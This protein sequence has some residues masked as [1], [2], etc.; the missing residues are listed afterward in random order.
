[1]RKI[2]LT[3]LV[4]LLGGVLLPVA[5]Q[6][7]YPPQLDAALRDLSQRIGVTITVPQLDAWTFEQ[8]RFT[9]TGLGCPEVTGAPAPDGISAYIFD[10]TYQGITYNYRVSLDESL[11]FPCNAELLQITPPPSPTPVQVTECPG[12]YAGFLEPRLG[13][14]SQGQLV[15]ENLP[16]RVR[17]APSVDAEQ[18]GTINQAD[19]FTVLDGP[20][21][22][23]GFVWWL[24]RTDEVEG[25]TAEGQPPDDYYLEPVGLIPT[26]T[27]PPPAPA[28]TPVAAA[29]QSAGIT[30]LAGVS[31]R[32]LQLYALSSP[33]TISS[34]MDV[35]S[36]PSRDFSGFSGLTWSPDGRFLAYAAP[37]EAGR[38]VFVTDRT[39][40]VVTP[41]ADDISF[42]FPPTFSPDSSEIFY[43]V[44]TGEFSPDAPTNQILNLFSAPVDGSAPPTLRATFAFGVG[45]GGGSSFPGDAVYWGEAGFAGSDIFFQL[46]PRGLLYT[47]RCTG[48]GIGLLDIATGETTVISDDLSRATLSPDGSR[49][50]GVVVTQPDIV[51]MSATGNTLNV[52]DLASGAVQTLQTASPPDQVAWGA[53]GSIFYSTRVQTD[54]IV[55]GSDTEALTQLGPGGLPLWA[56]GLHRVD[57][58]EATDTQIYSA[59]AFAIGR[60]YATPDGSGVYFSQVENAGA[61]VEFVNANGADLED[62][63]RFFGPTL[64]YLPLATP[65][66]VAVVGPNISRA[67]FSDSAFG[68]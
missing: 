2:M 44:D 13:L 7:D 21:C 45:C 32:Q 19:T 67:T 20:S 50:A 65:T 43:V 34:T 62:P 3:F 16:N 28:A 9:D 53:D 63:T 48:E 14:N 6:T 60:I 35:A 61:W 30:A 51:G 41:I 52:V 46:T 22:S 1:M 55:P 5:A 40:S 39:G 64:I 59:S 17:R 23:D 42:S 58:A 38:Q 27:P 68:G 33:T 11:V 36:A 66:D 49:L 31:N 56:V 15:P 26:L 24:V 25:W 12:D 8:Q 47:L 29:P 4:L 54:E 37:S 57:L 10:I 18:V